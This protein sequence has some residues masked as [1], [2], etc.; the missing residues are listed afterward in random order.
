MVGDSF[1]YFRE[2][3][4]VVFLSE[5]RFWERHGFVQQSLAYA[6]ANEGV[7]V[8]WLDGIGARRA[9][10]VQPTFLDALSVKSV[11]KWPLTRFPIMHRLNVR[12]QLAH[13][14][15][16][17]QRSESPSPLIWVQD[18]IHEDLAEKLPYI[19]VYSVFDDA[20]S[21][22]PSH[23]LCQKARVVVTQNQWAYE[24]LSEKLGPKVIRL[25]PP[26]QMGKES[27]SLQEYS[28]PDGFPKRKM[29][30]IL[31]LIHI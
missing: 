14:E 30:Y 2:R 6:L 29:G 23:P 24:R 5:S 17:R 28:F 31:S 1:Q 15:L 20:M 26:H 18:G 16:A 19:D 8:N 10:P 27:S 9:P 11:S 3:G 21:H 12:W 22:D 13:L 25:W 7:Y 4:G